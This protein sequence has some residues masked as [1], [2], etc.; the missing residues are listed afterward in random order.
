[1]IEQ[2]KVIRLETLAGV[3][4]KGLKQGQALLKDI[5]VTGC[6]AECPKDAGVEKNSHCILEIIPEEKTSIKSFELLAEAKWVKN[7]LESMEIGFFILEF[8][9]DLQFQYYVDYLA[10]RYAQE[11][12]NIGVKNTGN[13]PAG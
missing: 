11:G 12:R 4:I 9:K 3:A 2:R 10:W 5:S 13:Y 7:G 6:R 8:P 1:M